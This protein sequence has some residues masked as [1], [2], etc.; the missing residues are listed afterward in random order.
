MI[1]RSR[2][3]TEEIAECFMVSLLLLYIELCIAIS[4]LGQGGDGEGKISLQ[5]LH[6]MALDL[7]AIRDTF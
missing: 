2:G 1:Q 7:G 5:Q 4:E 3:D 6:Y